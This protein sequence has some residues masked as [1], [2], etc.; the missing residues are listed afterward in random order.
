M[1]FEESWNMKTYE[2]KCSTFGLSP[3]K[4]DLY[5]V[6]IENYN[7]P[8][9]LKAAMG[10]RGWTVSEWSNKKAWRKIEHTCRRA[11]K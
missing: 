7:P 10:F 11:H 5:C 2:E 3:V 6:L 8:K 4:T 1:S 9:S